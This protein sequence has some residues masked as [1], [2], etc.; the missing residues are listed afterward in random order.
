MEGSGCAKREQGGGVSSSFFWGLHAYQSM[1]YAMLSLS[2]KHSTSNNSYRRIVDACNDIYI[3][4]RTYVA[5][6]ATRVFFF[7]LND[8][9]P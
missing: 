4:R 7:F 9:A 6:L 5:L 2:T 8:G 1:C 3:D